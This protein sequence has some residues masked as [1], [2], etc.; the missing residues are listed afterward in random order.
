MPNRQRLLD[1]AN[2]R[3]TRLLHGLAEELRD[4]R[5]AA[6][7]R[8]ADVARAVGVSASQVSR[9]ERAQSPNITLRRATQLAAVV[10]LDLSVRCFPA[11]GGLRDEAHSAVI[12]R[13]RSRV[14][15]EFSW[16]LETPVGPVG[17]Q[18][19]FDVTLG[20]RGFQIG[21]E[22][23]TPLRDVQALVR[24]LTLKQRDGGIERVVLVV[25][26]TRGNRRLVAEA[27]PVL[28]LAFPLDTKRTLSALSRGTLPEANGLALL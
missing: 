23:E 9:A 4:A 5:L 3:S 28:R 14:S 15:P 7:I 20:G 11:G 27:A 1:Q 18:R 8:Q 6:G 26:A 12:G 2:R 13:L 19:A 22:I 25:A 17:D 10:R 21:V 16:R 24:R